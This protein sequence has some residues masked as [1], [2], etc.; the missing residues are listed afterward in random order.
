M[1]VAENLT[2]YYGDHAVIADVSFEIQA[3]EVVGLLGLNGAGKTTTLRVLS[4]L[5]VP[6]AGRI[7]VDGIDTAEE[8]EA[9]RSR[10]GFLP[11]I[12]PLYP[13]MRVSEYL[14]FA[15]RI[16]GFSGDLDAAI[17]DALS[18]TELNDARHDFIGTLSHGFHRRVGIAQA[19]VHRPK[20]I[21]LDEPTSGLD[22]RQIV[23][24][25]GVIRNL[26][27]NN[28]ILLSSHILRE[29]EQV[30]DRII[31]LQDGRI[32]ASGTHDELARKVAGKTTVKV[33]V[34]GAAIELVA[35]LG[36]AAEVARHNIDN[37]AGGLTRATVE[38]KSDSLEALAKTLVDSGLGLRGMQRVHLE[39]ENTF[40]KLTATEKNP[41]KEATS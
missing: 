40:L 1:I 3:G 31:V 21:L 23:H 6:T 29:V 12:P 35:A 24:M 20:L 30:C 36:K 26:G 7:R 14:A 9:V 22:P 16:K 2:K 27:R 39:L 34:R 17:N 18:A 38:L 5:L 11:E 33:E 32:V 41:S 15:A 28:T 4:G 37:E 19:I 13:E 10:I 8:P 25:R